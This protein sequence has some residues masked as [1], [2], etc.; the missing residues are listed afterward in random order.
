MMAA[1]NV[2]MS[3]SAHHLVS[4]LSAWTGVAP[5]VLLRALTYIP[6]NMLSL[7]DCP[8]GWSV[9]A[10]FVAAD[11]GLSPVGYRPTVH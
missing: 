1:P 5:C 8:E 11:L 2:A 4:G 10:E 6:E 3:A 7:L 9:L